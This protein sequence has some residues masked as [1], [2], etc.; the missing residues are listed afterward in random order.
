MGGSFH[1]FERFGFFLP[2][3]E[4]QS[5]SIWLHAASVGEVKSLGHLVNVLRQK[6]RG[7]RIIIS[8]MTK[9]GYETAG[10]VIQPDAV[11]MLP[12]ENP[13]ALASM[14]K[15]FNV[16]ILLV[17][18]TE[19]WPGFLDTLS[20]RVPL[21]LINGRISDKSFN[22]YKRLKFLSSWMLSRFCSIVAKSSLDAERLG[23]LAGSKER[24]MVGGNIK[25]VFDISDPN[26]Y[27]T[28]EFKDCRIALATCT[29]DPEE[30]LFLEAVK[31]AGESFDKIIIIPRHVKRADKIHKL[32]LAAGFEAS[33]LSDGAS[34]R[35]VIVDKFGLV[36]SFYRISDKIFVGGSLNKTGGHNIFEAFKYK[37]KVAFGPNMR[38][39]ADIAALGLE[40]G[41]AKEVKDVAELAHW[42]SEEEKPGNF[43]ALFTALDQYQKDR[44][45]ALLEC[46]DKCI[47]S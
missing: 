37:K 6:Y 10:R 19:L 44:F 4:D 7:Y 35:M 13:W 46:I 34:S 18:D 25:Y 40:N 8:V 16:K 20:K 42:L 28:K 38:N 41:V 9:G 27:V 22:S 2:I 23:E 36:E 26:A 24:I 1:Y 32:A 5:P 12:V 43:D 17:T 11:F 14:A 33:K 29:H 3:A 31:E 45:N 30:K 15:R 21:M 39:F 47:K